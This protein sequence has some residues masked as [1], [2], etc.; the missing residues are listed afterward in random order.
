MRM[1]LGLVGLMLVSACQV[2][3][4]AL[5]K[6]E[7]S[8]P[9]VIAALPAGVPTDI[10]FKSEDGCYAYAIEETDPLVGYPLRDRNGNPVCPN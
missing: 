2:D 7:L 8:S 3:Q 5:T 10:V 1:I 9:Q 6:E 4:S